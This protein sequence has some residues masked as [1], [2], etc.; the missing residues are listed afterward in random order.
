MALPFAT[1]TAKLVRA[2]TRLLAV[3]DRAGQF[4]RLIHGIFWAFM[5]VA[6]GGM[7]LDHGAWTRSETVSGP[8]QPKAESSDLYAVDI[9]VGVPFWLGLRLVNTDSA[10]RRALPGPRFL[11][12][13][14]EI[15]LPR[16]PAAEISRGA[17][18]SLGARQ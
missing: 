2:R 4:P 12:D 9:G 6:I 14:R 11:V 5:L 1:L 18:Y 10:D 7:L 17:A 15:G 3:V 16:T 13:G 8:F